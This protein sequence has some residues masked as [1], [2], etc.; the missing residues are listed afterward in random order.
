MEGLTPFLTLVLPLQVVAACVVAY[1]A[2]VAILAG[3]IPV[4]YTTSFTVSTWVPAHDHVTLGIQSDS[5]NTFPTNKPAGD[6]AKLEPTASTQPFVT[7]L[8]RVLAIT[9]TI[10]SYRGLL[11]EGQEAQALD[12]TDPSSRSSSGHLPGE[13]RTELCSS[14]KNYSGPGNNVCCRHGSITKRTKNGLCRHAVPPN[15]HR[16]FPGRLFS[17]VKPPR[18]SEEKNPSGITHPLSGTLNASL[19]FSVGTVLEI[20]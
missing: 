6:F 10:A 1:T 4:V 2:C 15:Q 5:T 9:K 7:S 14:G 16:A 12:F 18:T 3:I 8:F 20:V 11:P 17:L 19:L 13:D